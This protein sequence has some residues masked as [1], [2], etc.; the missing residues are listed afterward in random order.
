MSSYCDNCGRR[1]CRCMLNGEGELVAYGCLNCRDN[2][3][4]NCGGGV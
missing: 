1:H 2:G 4:Q 3:C